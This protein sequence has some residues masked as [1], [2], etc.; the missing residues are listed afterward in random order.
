MEQEKDFNYKMGQ[1]TGQIGALI[2]SNRNLADSLKRLEEKFER[3][4]DS[5]ETRIDA[6]IQDTVALKVRMS[7]VGGVGGVVGGLIVSYIS[8]IFLT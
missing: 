4:L 6:N 2:D 1:L 8:H 5:M 3:A 7:L